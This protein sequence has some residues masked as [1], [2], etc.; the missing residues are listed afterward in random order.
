MD[1][2]GGRKTHRFP[3]PYGLGS[4]SLTHRPTENPTG[5][6]H[7][8]E[9]QGI[10]N[11]APLCSAVQNDDNIKPLR[12]HSPS[13]PSPIRGRKH[14]VGFLLTWK[15]DLQDTIPNSGMARVGSN[16]Y[17]VIP[18]SEPESHSLTDCKGRNNLKP[19]QL[20]GDSV[21]STE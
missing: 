6:T 9:L 3:P 4:L 19:S 13:Q 7:R 16:Y 20:V 8:Q 1:Y 12:D 15:G 18:A 21:S 5:M 14:Y 2:S 11:H 17:F 10:Q